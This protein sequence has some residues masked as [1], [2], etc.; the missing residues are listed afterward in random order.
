MSEACLGN[1]SHSQFLS[2]PSLQQDWLTRGQ[3]S[4][5]L[6]DHTQEEDPVTSTSKVPSHWGPLQENIYLVS[7]AT[8]K[9][10][11]E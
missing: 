6:Q 5:C 8:L 9:S 2:T 10:A 4:T 1:P 7:Q 11:A 3:H